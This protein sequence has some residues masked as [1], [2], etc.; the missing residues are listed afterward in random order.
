M[1]FDFNA[2]RQS[3]RLV[4]VPVMGEASG[5]HNNP[6]NVMYSD[7]AFDDNQGSDEPAPKSKYGPDLEP[8][9]DD[10]DDIDE[11]DQPDPSKEPK[12]SEDSKDSKDLENSDEPDPSKKSE[13]SKGNGA[14]GPWY[15]R[16][17]AFIK[18]HPQTS[19]IVG[20][21]ILIAIGGSITYALTRPSKPDNSQITAKKAVKAVPP[22]PITSP[23]TG[24]VV[25]AEDAKRPATGIMIENTVFARPQSGLKEAGVVYEAIAEAGITRFLALYQEGKPGN[26]GPVRSSRPYY[27]D[28]AHSFDAAYG[29]VG[30]SPDALSKIKAD[31]VKDLDQFFN[32]A[33]Y[34]RVS[35]RDAPH[36]VYTDMGQ[37]DTA[38][39]QKGWTS[40]K[41]TSW[42]RKAD[43]PAKGTAITANRVDIAISGPTY[44]THYDYNPDTN[45]Y[46]R[47]E[48]GEPHIDAESKKQLSPKVVIGMVI[49]YSLEADNYHSKYVLDGTGNMTV[50]QDGIA[51]KGTWKRGTGNAQYEFSDEA[52]HPLKL[53][54]GQTWITAVGDASAITYAPN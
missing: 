39:S 49:P 47:S 16:W 28:W 12:E 25:S 44:N 6:N 27:V 52:G 14:D 34:H 51:T 32:S 7:A 2:R 45:T 8:F 15:K 10:M 5:P 42:P 41:F 1:D 33:Y 13:S 23:M 53:D 17:I 37:L 48:G 31:G 22:A 40:S 4:A 21:V 36:N 9:M 46:N 50:F 35:S 11:T 24:M 43:A 19:I 54:A 38:N 20:A 18:S 29:H 30:G 3:A 26:I